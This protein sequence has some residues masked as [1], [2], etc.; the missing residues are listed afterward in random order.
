MLSRILGLVAVA[1][2][3]TLLAKQM[4]KSAGKG[5]ESRVSIEVD[6]PVRT[7]YDQFTQF[8]QFPQFMESVH[9]VRQLDD[10]RLHWKADVFGK[11]IEWDA[12]ITEQ[13]PD[14]KIAWRSTSGTPNGGTVTFNALPGGRTTVTL[15]LY[16][17]PQDAVETIGDMVGAVRMQAR[18]NL[19]RFKDMLEK[20]GSETGAWRG[21][22][23]KESTT[24]PMH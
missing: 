4:Q 9:E 19:Q 24:G 5:S 14:K 1:V 23:A 6:L 15:D 21:A 17:E 12:E 10:K 7:V 3:G 2:G 22:I 8:E 16:Y 13:I 11:V 18:S 20:R